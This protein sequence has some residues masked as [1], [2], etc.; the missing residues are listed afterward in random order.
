MDE[1]CRPFPIYAYVIAAG[2]VVHTL[3][4][5]RFYY[6]AIRDLLFRPG[7]VVRVVRASHPPFHMAEKT[8]P[9]HAPSLDRRDGALQPS[10]QYD[11]R[12]MRLTS[13]AQ[14]GL[15]SSR[16][17]P[18]V[19]LGTNERGGQPWTSLPRCCSSVSMSTK[20]PSPSLT[21]LMIAVP[22]SCR[23]G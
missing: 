14:R 17:E 15:A 11:F 1:S 20:T 10:R 22:T 9:V 3:D 2:A 23:W 5:Y 13:G 21:H 12:E 8:R 4:G 6:P 19:L 7:Q 16:P 18:H